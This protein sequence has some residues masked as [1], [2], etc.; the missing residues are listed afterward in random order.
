MGNG[1]R[2]ADAWRNHHIVM[3]KR[4]T[5][6]YLGTTIKNLGFIIGSLFGKSSLVR[7]EMN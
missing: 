4:Q 6:A 7:L 3:P 2:D 1:L 5:Q